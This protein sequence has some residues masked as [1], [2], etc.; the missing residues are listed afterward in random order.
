MIITVKQ[1]RG[2]V[3]YTVDTSEAQYPWQYRDAIQQALLLDGLE[4]GTINEIFNQCQDKATCDDKCM[5]PQTE[6]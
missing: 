4:Q 5:Q 6:G 1:K 2:Q 3:T